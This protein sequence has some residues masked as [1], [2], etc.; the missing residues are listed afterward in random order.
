MCSLRVEIHHV[1]NLSA[2]R[3][4]TTR[5]DI[6]ELVLKSRTR[7]PYSDAKFLNNSYTTT[8]CTIDI[9]ENRLTKT[10]E[11]NENNNQIDYRSNARWVDVGT[12]D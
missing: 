1:F 9:S 2:G 10:R 4:L 7:T 8:T 11:N 3:L 6:R 12:Y 5:L